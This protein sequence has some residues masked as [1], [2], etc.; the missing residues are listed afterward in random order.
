M[1][2]ELVDVLTD[3]IIRMDE[4]EVRL[5]TE[6]EREYRDVRRHLKSKANG[7]VLARNYVCAALTEARAGL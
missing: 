2:N 6:A 4:A 3:L 1:N 5:I 7:V